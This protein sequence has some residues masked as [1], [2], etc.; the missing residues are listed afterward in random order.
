M[1]PLGSPLPAFALPDTEGVVIRAGAHDAARGLLV[2]FICNHCPFVI[3]L[4][5]ALAAFAEDYLPRGLAII[6]ISSNDA[7]S[8]PQDGPEE[9]K[10]ERAAAGYHFPYLYDESQ[11]VALAFGARCT[12]DFF[13]YGPPRGG[14]RRLLYRG[15]FDDSRP[16]NGRPVTGDSLRAACDAVLA[17]EAVAGEQRPSLGCNI[18]WRPG[19]SPEEQL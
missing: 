6:A 10:A 14:S 1:I 8:Y 3:H 13:L 7:E 16:G 4:R 19:Q 2:M 9:M 12:P 17:G 18:K 11:E 5:S 15:E